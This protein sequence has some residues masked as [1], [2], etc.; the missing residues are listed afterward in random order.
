MARAARFTLQIAGLI[1]AE[2]TSSILAL[3]RGCAMI[4][5]RAIIGAIGA[6]VHHGARA[7]ALTELRAEL[8]GAAGS[9]R[10]GRRRV[11]A[12]L[13]GAARSA[14]LLGASIVGVST[15]LSVASKRVRN[16]VAAKA[17]GVIAHTSVGADTRLLDAAVVDALVAAA[18]API[19]GRAFTKV[20]R[21]IANQVSLAGRPT[22]HGISASIRH[23]AASAI[24]EERVR[25][26]RIAHLSCVAA[27][28]CVAANDRA[29]IGHVRNVRS[30][31]C[32]VERQA[33]IDPEE[34]RAC[35]ERF[36]ERQ[37]RHACT[38]PTNRLAPREAPRHR[39]PPPVR[40]ALILTYERLDMLASDSAEHFRYLIHG[41]ISFHHPQ[42]GRKQVPV[43][44]Q[45]PARV[46]TGA[47]A[48][49]CV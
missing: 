25:S 34:R 31:A 7:F 22:L 13:T 9:G 1:V 4:D 6:R 28:V 24:A 39:S 48:S 20:I 23:L 42:S 36:D 33:R 12:D 44:S 45:P 29:G 46:L 27:D 8:G 11:A 19:G 37:D 2:A 38:R 30:V 35:S 14:G 10:V 47:L 41:R 40:R 43:R 18:V 17:D 32:V 3:L 15:V 5:V 49:G 26:S 16:A 21:W